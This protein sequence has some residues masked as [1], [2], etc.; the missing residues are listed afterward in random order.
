MFLRPS[1]VMFSRYALFHT[2][3]CPV[4]K[5]FGMFRLVIYR[6]FWYSSCGNSQGW[7]HFSSVYRFLVYFITFDR[8]SSYFKTL[9]QLFKILQG[10]F[11]CNKRIMWEKPTIHLYPQKISVAHKVAKEELSLRFEVQ[12]SPVFNLWKGVNVKLGV[13]SLTPNSHCLNVFDEW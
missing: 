10:Y 9:Y 13:A 3:R 6:I 12:L 8:L 1:V 11:I 4:L 2:S 7:P 5:G